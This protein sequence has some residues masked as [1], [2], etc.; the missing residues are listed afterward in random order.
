VTKNP[1]PASALD[2]SVA[3]AYQAALVPGLMAPWGEAIAAAAQ[4]R[5]G[6][7]VLDVACGTGV[8]ARFAA[9]RCGSGGRVVGIDIDHGMLAVAKAQSKKDG[10]DVEFVHGSAVALPFDSASF[11]AV[12]CLQGLQYF[13]DQVGAMQEFRRVLRPGAPLVAM[14]WSHL[15]ACKGQWAMVTA[16]ERRGID[17]AAARKPFGSSDPAALQALAL[18]AGFERV[19]VRQEQR[20][21]RF[22]SVASFVESMRKGAPST[23]LALDQVPAAEW[24]RFVAEVETM[25]AAWTRNSDFDFPV[26]CNVL[27]ARS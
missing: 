10:V 20:L 7:R 13:P 22:P 21:G 2:T 1:P 9:Q 23:R 6:M 4:V 15:Q 8:A 25:L 26:E 11:D 14:T 27:E 17:A 19:A 16:L 12:L 5:D 18:N 3:D 24:P